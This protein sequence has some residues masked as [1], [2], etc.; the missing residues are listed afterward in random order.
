[1]SWFW[2]VVSAVVL[3]AL[4]LAADWFIESINPLNIEEDGD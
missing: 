4:I 2:I 3:L 1:M